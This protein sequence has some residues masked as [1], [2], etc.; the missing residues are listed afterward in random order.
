M[1][2]LPWRRRHRS[3]RHGVPFSLRCVLATLC[4]LAL[5][6]RSP[7]LTA[8][9][10]AVGT[11]TPQT[12][13]ALVNQ[14]GGHVP[15]MVGQG[16][17]LYIAEGSR[18]MVFD[19]SDPGRPQQLGETPIL[20]AKALQIAVSGT[21]LIVATQG[22]S[23]PP[24]PTDIIAY[25]VHDV[26]QPRELGRITLH[27]TVNALAFA[28]TIASVVVAGQQ[29]NNLL[30]LDFSQPAVPR[31]AGQLAVA[32]P[33]AIAADTAD[34]YLLAAGALHVLSIADPDHPVIIGTL[35]LPSPWNAPATARALVFDHGTLYALEGVIY[36]RSVGPGGVRSIAVSDPTH[37]R[38][39]DTLSNATAPSTIAV[40]G[41]TAYIGTGT[42]LQAIDL[43][44]PAHLRLRTSRD[45]GQGSYVGPLAETGATLAVQVSDYSGVIHTFDIRDPALHSAPG[46]INTFEG[47]GPML[48]DRHFLYVSDGIF[49][50]SIF[51]LSDP[52]NPRQVASVPVPGGIEALAIHSA[53]LYVGGNPAHLQD[54]AVFGQLTVFD[55]TDPTQPRAVGGLTV[56][57][58][59]R[60][61]A[62]A[63][64][65]LYAA[66][67][68]SCA[69]A[70][71][72]GGLYVFDVS[73]A[74]APVQV[75]Y[76]PLVE[77]CN[78]E[79]ELTAVGTTVYVTTLE[80]AKTS[81]VHIINV[82]DV[83]NPLDISAMQARPLS[84]GTVSGHYLYRTDQ[85]GIAVDDVSDAA[86]PRNVGH[87]SSPGYIAALAL[88][89]PT[90]VGSGA[91]SLEV[92]DLTN[93]QQPRL[94]GV[95]RQ[96]GTIDLAVDGDIIYAA[97]LGGALYVLQALAARQATVPP[98]P[99]VSH[100]ERYYPETG[101]RIANDAFWN[102]F[103]A[104][105]GATTLG[106]PASRDFRLDGFL[107]QIFQRQ[108]LQLFP[109]G[110][111]HLLN[112]FDPPLL[113]YTG[114]HGMPVPTGDATLLTTVPNV[115]DQ[116]ALLAW[117]QRNAP[118]TFGSQPVNFYQAFLHP[119]A[120]F[121]PAQP[122]R[123]A[124]ETPAGALMLW[125]LPTGVPTAIAGHA[126]LIG[127]RWQR[128]AMLYDTTCTCT[129]EIF[130]GDDLKALLT[131][132]QLPAD[133]TRDAAYSPYIGQ[134][135]PGASAW[136]CRPNQ[137][138]DTDLTN[139]FVPG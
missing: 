119:G 74:G 18:V 107:V 8:S 5:L 37:P 27:D 103:T 129:Q 17:A 123:T 111:V 61:M 33:T 95:Y 75:G 101:Y 35:N 38:L 12:G 139:A 83:R 39:L 23:F 46:A 87:V 134:Y 78:S 14:I 113:P 93:P 55:V 90:L 96:F 28:G 131:A 54:P 116:P 22:Q 91:D 9:A 43:S 25:D 138:L 135:C 48:R 68:P 20:P 42:T 44:D 132:D 21:T 76:L 122:D 130:A 110:S 15:A 67:T 73:G 1:R 10:A 50:L 4:M 29:G 19:A 47:L 86:H 104:L 137:L 6:V 79:I 64:A 40:Q 72:A 105:G 118:D 127:L 3:N 136:L 102:S 120:T 114:F 82:A 84:V 63:G 34:V 115:A 112:L 32:N 59:P 133:L 80:D 85:T 109:D 52:T 26:R 125:G 31:L 53:R 100:D 69:G 45:F 56:N 51:D 92:F 97:D 108:V 7:Q 58:G 89:G 81:T 66:A 124:T 126:N 16:S 11:T 62:V 30:L 94:T 41:T 36:P 70:R 88:D 128:G 60:S 117:I 71:T 57:G 106:Y 98:P 13:V 24:T 99:S 2:L 49:H 77:R 65:Y 121:D